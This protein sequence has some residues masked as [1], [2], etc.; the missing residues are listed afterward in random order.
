MWLD[1]PPHSTDIQSRTTHKRGSS[2]KSHFYQIPSWRCPW[3]W[4]WKQTYYGH[5]L[6]LSPF[7]P[8][9]LSR[10]MNDCWELCFVPHVRLDEVHTTGTNTNTHSRV[11][12]SLSPG[13]L[14][15][16]AS[17]PSGL[18]GPPLHGDHPTQQMLPR[19]ASSKQRGGLASPSMSGCS[20][21]EHVHN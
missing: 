6:T 7:L 8:G 12:R 16:T 13:S 19:W 3:L 2:N 10:A 20:V 15:G 17:Q 5:S 9:R 1:P 4:L 21:R 11:T 14:G 18:Y